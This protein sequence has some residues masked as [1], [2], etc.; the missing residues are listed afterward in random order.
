MLHTT[1]FSVTQEPVPTV[2]SF[3]EILLE[4]WDGEDYQTEIFQLLSHLSLQ[5]FEGQ[6]SD[7][8]PLILAL[9]VTKFRVEKKAL[10]LVLFSNSIRSGRA[11]LA[12]L[13]AT[14]RI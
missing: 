3:L 5:P 12:T 2:E 11:L 10:L 4:V 8:T 14:L 6:G 13:E 9:A 7:R 1:A